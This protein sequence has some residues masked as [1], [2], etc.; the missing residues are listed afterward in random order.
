MLDTEPYINNPWTTVHRRK[1][2]TPTPKET[3]NFDPSKFRSFRNNTY[4]DDPSK[5]IWNKKKYPIKCGAMI[6]DE[7][8]TKIILVQNNYSHKGHE[9][10][11]LP[12]GHRENNE[13]YATCATRE[14]E[15]ETGILIV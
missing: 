6:F 10:W 3:N 2:Y 8:L 9:K 14:V 1:R 5:S 12:K 13:T 11:G 15:E 7:T 4:E